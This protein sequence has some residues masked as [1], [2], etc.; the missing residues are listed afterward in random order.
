MQALLVSDVSWETRSP[1]R[2]IFRALVESWMSILVTIQSTVSGDTNPPSSNFSQVGSAS[3]HKQSNK[4]SQK[5]TLDDDD[6]G[7]SDRDD[8][9][10]RRKRQKYYGGIEAK[11][12]Q[13]WACPFYQ[14]EPH[15][16]CFETEFGD[17]RKCARSPGFDQVHRVK[18]G[19]YFVRNVILAHHFLGTISI[20][21]ILRNI[22]TDAI[23]SS[24]KKT[25]LQIIE[26]CRLLV[27]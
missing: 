20:S 13:K 6:H 15:R 10:N 11:G 18:S 12:R 8:N 16:Y 25:I 7:S 4:G 5:R 24:R 3:K 1:L 2:P 21:A 23:L 19:F 17:F 22:V 9:N 14:R 27:T 26:G